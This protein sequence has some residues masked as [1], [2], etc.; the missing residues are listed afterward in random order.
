[1]TAHNNSEPS[2]WVRK[3]ASLVKPGGEVLDLACG[4]GRH[5]IFMADLGHK[6]LA[7]DHDEEKLAVLRGIK[8]INTLLIDLEKDGLSFKEKRFSAI[9]VTNYLYR[10]FLTSL[11][12]I[13]DQS[14]VIIYETFS[15][16]NESFGKPSNKSYLLKHHELL[17]VFRKKLYVV[18]FEQGRI[19]LPKPAV[20][21]RICA[22]TYHAAYNDQILLNQVKG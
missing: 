8:N 4:E 18:S 1:M 6:V 16:G 13:L 21:Q 10:P 12:K 9:I 14:G 17:D 5:S 22:I 19:N 20:I 7:T 2:D 11:M 3:W 15:Q